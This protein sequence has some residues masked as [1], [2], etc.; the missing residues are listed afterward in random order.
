MAD[1]AASQND[2]PRG[3]TPDVVGVDEEG[4]RLRAYEISQRPDAGTPEE[5]WHRAIAELEAESEIEEAV[6]RSQQSS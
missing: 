5:N 2:Q 4:V 6:D 1:K 3:G